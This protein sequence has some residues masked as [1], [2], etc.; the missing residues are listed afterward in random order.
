MRA[1]LVYNA[2]SGGAASEREIRSGLAT[3]GWNVDRCLSERDL[4]DR[5]CRATDVVVVAGG[6]GTVG[7]LAKRLAGTGLPMAIVPMGTANN[8][9]R[10]L[11]IGVDPFAAVAGLARS[12]ERHVDLG[13][14]RSRQGTEYFLEGFGLGVL[15]SVVAERASNDARKLHHAI[16]L[17][18]AELDE[19]VPGH[20]ELEVD[21]RDLSGRYVLAAVMNARSLGPAL[22]VAP[23]ARCDDGQLDVV[24]IR[25]EAKATLLAH[26]RR[27]AENVDVALPSFETTRATSV[28]VRADGRWAHIDDYARRLEG[29]TCIEVAAGVVKVLVPCV[30]AL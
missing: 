27:A 10:S 8:V 18:A 30:A 12:G 13:V 1:T 26:L 17:I 15:A 14:V 11:G 5:L 4:D 6:D 21:G 2:R 29:D 9:A 7:T 23:Q 28:R 20:F 25:P 22:G 19:F 3:I 16:A 24:M